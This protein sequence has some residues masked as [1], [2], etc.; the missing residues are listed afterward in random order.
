MIGVSLTKFSNMLCSKLSLNA[1]QNSTNE[2][3]KKRKKEKKKLHLLGEQAFAY[4]NQMV[5]YL[6]TQTRNI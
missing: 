6:C 3:D 5:L 2:E 1:Y 4:N